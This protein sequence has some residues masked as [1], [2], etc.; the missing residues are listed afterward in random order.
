MTIKNL[1]QFQYITIVQNAC[2]QKTAI[3]TKIYFYLHKFNFSLI[4]YLF[5]VLNSYRALLN[6]DSNFYVINKRNTKSNGNLY[7]LFSLKVSQ[8]HTSYLIMHKTESV[9]LFLK[10]LGRNLLKQSSIT[11]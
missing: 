9:L 10:L 11:Y 8:L 3:L 4:R 1:S 5:Y 6:N 2:S 7:N